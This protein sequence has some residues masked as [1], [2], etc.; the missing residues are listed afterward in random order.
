MN[1]FLGV[2]GTFVLVYGIYSIIAKILEIKNR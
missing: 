2:L 1:I